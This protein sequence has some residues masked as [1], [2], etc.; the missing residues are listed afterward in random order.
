MTAT[1]IVGHKRYKL[2]RSFSAKR[3]AQRQAR[4][5]R[6]EGRSARVTKTEVAYHG[7]APS[8]RYAVWVR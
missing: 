2:F 3:E 1:I 5:I 8:I 4:V 6:S 7:A